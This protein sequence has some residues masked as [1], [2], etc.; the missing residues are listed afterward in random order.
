MSSFTSP[1]RG[2]LAGLRIIEIAGIGPGP[3]AGMLLADMGAEV[4]RVDRPGGSLFSGDRT[5][6]DFLNRGKRAFCADLKNPEAV[7]LVLQ[8]V[9]TAD[10]LLE[11]FRPGVAEKLGIGPDTSLERN[12]RLVYGRMT[13]WGQDGPLALRAGH[14]INYIAVAGALHPIGRRGEKPTLP[15]NLVGD[16]GGGGMLLAFGMVCALLEAKTSGLGQVVDAAM[17]DGAALLMT[18]IFAAAQSGFW[19]EQRGTNMLDGGAPF[20]DVYATSDGKYVAV[21]AIEPQFFQALVVG[22]GMPEEAAAQYDSAEWPRL[23]AR[24][25]EAFAGRTREEWA[26]LFADS[27]ACVSPVLAMS[28]ARSHP[29]N[30]ARAGFVEREGVWQP[31]T[32][33]RFGRTDGGEP[34]PAVPAGRDTLALLAELDI[35]AEEQQ[36]L[37]DS[38][39]VVAAR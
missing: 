38:A 32:A 14:D 13:G 6:L 23:R 24:F 30:V 3:F 10:G 27:D 22:L 39:A 11:G 1:A 12:P 34:A 8:L 25:E 19:S 28:E 21:G 33:P 36:R 18:S 16:F 29:H 2:P 20:Y 7:A 37:L 5:E 15:L 26:A 9:A 31:R 35:P 4:I 17:V